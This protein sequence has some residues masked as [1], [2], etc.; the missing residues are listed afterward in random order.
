MYLHRRCAKVAAQRNVDLSVKR[1][2]HW[3]VRIV[4]RQRMGQDL[5]GHRLLDQV[6]LS[7]LVTGH[8]HLNGVGG[9]VRRIF[10]SGGSVG[11]RRCG[12]HCNNV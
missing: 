12:C 11:V 2:D 7:V 8:E 1:P 10:M 3:I 4:R 5:A 6:I 9:R